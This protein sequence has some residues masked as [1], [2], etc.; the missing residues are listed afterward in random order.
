MKKNNINGSITAFGHLRIRSE[1]SCE[2]GFQ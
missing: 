1:E 2:P